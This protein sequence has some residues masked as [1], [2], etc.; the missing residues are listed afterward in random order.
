MFSTLVQVLFCCPVPTHGME[1]PPL[2]QHAKLGAPIEALVPHQEKQG[3]GGLQ[4]T[5]PNPLVLQQVLSSLHL[6]RGASVIPR[7]FM[8]KSFHG[9][10]FHSS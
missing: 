2:G 5:A 6:K 7:I 1:A 8:S 9:W 4:A 10:L 3:L